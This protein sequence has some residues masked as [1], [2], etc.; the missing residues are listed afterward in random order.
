MGNS[1]WLVSQW[2]A[3]GTGQPLPV[4]LDAGTE[5]LVQKLQA[6]SES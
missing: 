6:C 2:V 5:E 4:R 3:E 1:A